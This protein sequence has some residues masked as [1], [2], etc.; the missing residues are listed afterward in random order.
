MSWT[1]SLAPTGM[2]GLFFAITSAR[3]ILGPVTDAVMGAMNDKYNTN[4]P[5][6]RDQY[7]HFCDVAIN[8]DANAAQ[9][10]SV[11]EEC[12]LFL[13]NPQQQSCP[14][15]CLEC[16]TW[17]ATDPSTFWYLLMIAGIAAPLSV[18]FFLPFLRGKRVRDDKCYGLFRV[19]KARFLGIYGAQ[20][21]DEHDSDTRRRRQGR[22]V[23]GHLESNSSSTSAVVTNGMDIELT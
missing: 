2:E 19:N 12:N 14:Q 17:V 22:Q 4:C 8:N 3:A 18:W 15:T 13:D 6:C 9:C 7:G 20:D 23:Y 1:A 21:D 16:P 10:V 5:D 11:Q